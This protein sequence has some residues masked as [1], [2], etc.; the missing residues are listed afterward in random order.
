MGKFQPPHTFSGIHGSIEKH[1]KFSDLLKAIDEQFAKSYKSLANTLI[2]QFPSLRLTGIRGVCDH[3]MHM[4]DILAQ[5][6]SL[7]VSMSESFLVHYILCTLPPQYS[8]SK[9]SYNSHKEKGKIVN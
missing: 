4:M 7:E 1:V 8:P 3:I 9:I 5:L 2:I 6:K